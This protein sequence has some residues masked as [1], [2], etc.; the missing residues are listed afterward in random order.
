MKRIRNMQDYK[1][2]LPY[3]SEIF[4]IYQPLLGWK[5]KRIAKRNETGY[6]GFRERI[7]A[8][9]A[10]RLKPEYTATFGADCQVELSEIRAA[11]ARDG[12]TLTGRVMQAVAAHLPPLRKYRPEVW[13][14][15]I[16][17]QELHDVLNRQVRDD[18]VQRY[19]HLCREQL[20]KRGALITTAEQVM[21]QMV[22]LESRAAAMLILLRDAKAVGVLKDI[23]YHNAMQVQSVMNVLS[24]ALKY[25]DPF[26][27][28]DPKKDLDR[29]GLSPVGVVH[30]FRQYFFELD[31][32]L[33]TPVGHVWVAPGS[34]VELAEVTTR[35]TVIERM[36]ETLNEVTLKTESTLTTQE[37]FSEAVKEDN[38]TDAKFGAS[39]SAQQNWVWGSANETAS[40]DYGTTQSEAREQAHKHMRQQ[41]EKVS[42]EMKQS[43]K[44]TFKVVTETTETSSKRYVLTNPTPD[45][46][47]YE[48][49]RKMRQ[50]AVQVQD[51]GTYLCWQTYVDDPGAHLG[52]ANLV[53]LSETPDLSKVPH[54]EMIVPA[55]PTTTEAVVDIPYIGEDDEND[56]SY[57]HGTENDV[58]FGENTDH[59]QADF[60]QTVFAP[61]E[62][63]RLEHVDFE[64]QG[65][66]ARVSLRDVKQEGTS[67]KWMFHA[68]LDYVNFGG[69]GGIKVKMIMRWGPHQ[70][71]A[72]I[73]KENEKRMA[74]FTA[75]SEQAYKKTFMEA[76]RERIKIASRIVSRRYEDLREEERIVVYR[77][78][79]Q[80]MLAPEKR[81]P[82]PDANSRH[83][84]AELL[85]SIFDVD[86]MLYFVAPEWWRP[87]LHQSHQSM[88]SLV[89]ARNSDGSITQGPDG[90][91]V[92]V[93]AANQSIPVE[94]T[95][96][97]GGTQEKRPDN[98]Y[99]T[100]ESHPATL[101]SSLGWLLQLDGDNLRN[102]FLNAPWVKAVMPIRPGK[103]K[104]ALNWLKQVEGMNTLTANDLYAGPEPQLQ[105]KT[106]FEALDILA[107][108]VAEKHQES[109]E[110]KVFPD[111]AAPGDPDSAVTA[112]PVDRV[113][114]HG[115]YPLQGGFRSKPL[116]DFEVFDQWIEIVPTDQVAAVAVEYDPI[117]G[118]QIR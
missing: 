7:L 63:Y 81:I 101:G 55:G 34:T 70:D 88:G 29:V 32:F 66:D 77:K 9:V 25:V 58:G 16:Q 8:T 98:Y 83:V 45:L 74:A 57:E 1:D 3:S 50:V 60:P 105:G 94:H 53:H 61:Q 24:G 17:D 106:I 92:M 23:F 49:R 41:T 89:A 71:I 37:D 47:N 107:D 48:L 64:P 6:T 85:N 22:D 115:F 26:E 96:G 113:Y 13:G 103:E 39:V 40:F 46:I 27:S 110:T 14:E 36:T 43:L 116:D 97:W 51:I 30:L 68:H 112:T 78:L 2:V 21:T 4:G 56:I 111:P 104:A 20:G 91:P 76:A 100:E 118:R 65:A 109:V 90:R 12:F 59:I 69:A 114:E 87:R 5:S 11:S 28:L 79:I 38:R 10:A 73:T 99:I 93:G 80:E 75:A 42:T 82:M 18:A 86:K 35:K 67:T 52:V 72:A 102:A 117:T 31:T 19:R 62:F 95:V 108:K 33:G 54:P 15:A 84:V 44:T